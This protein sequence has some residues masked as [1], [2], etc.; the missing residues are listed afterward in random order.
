VHLQQV[1]QVL[2]IYRLAL[3]ILA[4]AAAV[5]VTMETQEMVE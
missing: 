5:L 2:D 3:I 1:A 4:A